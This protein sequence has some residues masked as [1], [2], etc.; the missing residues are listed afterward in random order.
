MTDTVS[1]IVP[2]YNAENFIKET[3]DSVLKQTYT[4]WELLLVD[5]CSKDASCD[6][7]KSYDDER[8]KLFKQPENL[9]AYAARNCGLSLALGRYI[10]FLDADDIWEP[11]KLE[12]QMKFLK[13]N[14]AG[15][16]FTSYEFADENGIGNGSVVRVPKIL[17]YKKALHNTIIFTSTV[18]IDRNIVSDDLIKM[19]HM[20]SEDTA[21][22][23]TI[24]KAGHT[25]WGLNEN[26]VRYRRFSGTLSANKAVALKRIWNLLRKVAGLNI[27]AASFHFCLWAV[28]AVQRR[29]HKG[30]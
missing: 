14:N 17:P 10:A 13:E 15:F 2:V 16:T 6:I 3:I 26:L 5:D 27:F 20:A 30:R 7:I 9:G 25:A 24:M 29:V 28:L 8:I 12:H 21:T 1:I 11:K 4:D 23:W 18:L 19:P 22:W